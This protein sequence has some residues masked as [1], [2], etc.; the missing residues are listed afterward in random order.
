MPDFD[1]SDTYRRGD[2]EFDLPRFAVH[3]ARP[4]PYGS[5]SKSLGA[6]LNPY[7]NSIVYPGP[8][9]A[10]HSLSLSG[11]QPQHPTRLPQI[12]DS[13]MLSGAANLVRSA[14][15]SGRQRPGN[16]PQ[17]DIERAYSDASVSRQPQQHPATNSLYPSS[18][19]YGS[20]AASTVDP[21]SQAHEGPAYTPRRSL[22]HIVHPQSGPYNMEAGYSSSPVYSDPYAKNGDPAPVLNTPLQNM[23]SPTSPLRHPASL[24]PQQSPNLQP[25]HHSIS[26]TFQRSA[27]THELAQ[28]LQPTSASTIPSPY[29][30][31][32][33]RHGSS[34]TPVSPMVGYP[35]RH[36]S[37]QMYYQRDEDSAVQPMTIDSST[38]PPLPQQVGFRRI[39][40]TR[41][42]RPKVNSQP[43][44]RRAD[45][46]GGGV[47][48]SPLRS[49]TTNLAQTY[50][51]CNPQFRYESTHN[52]RRVLTKPSKPVH[53]DG[54]DNEDYDYILYVNDC[55]GAEDSGNRYL[56]LDVLGQGTFGQVVKCQNMKTHEIVAVKVVKNKPAYFNQSMMEVTILELLNN[57][58]DPHDEHHILRLRDTFIHKNHLCLVFE[59]LS[60][61]LY[62]LIKQNSFGGLSTQLVKVFTQ[63]LLDSLSILNE[64]KLIHCDL[65]PENILLVSLQTPQIKII[66]FGSA[67]HERQTVYTYIQ[68]RFYRSPE[69]LLGLPYTSAIDMWSLGCIAVELFLGLP[70]FPGTS[71]YNQI[72]RI[73]D[74]LGMPPQYML[75]MGK[76]TS[77]FFSPYSDE[78]GRKKHRLKSLEQYSREH[79]TPEQPGK[80]YFTANTLPEIIRT[81]P[82]PK[83]ATKPADLEK[84]AQNR[85]AFTD[86]VQGLLQIDPLLRWTPQQARK[87]P[88]ITGEK[89]IRPFVPGDLAGRT[90]S[91]S[92]GSLPPSVDPKRPYGGLVPSQ[93]KGTRAYQDA[94]SYNQHLAQHQAYTAQAASQA[95]Q[96]QIRNPYMQDHQ[97]P[98]VQG[99]SYERPGYSSN[100]STSQAPQ[101]YQSASQQP[102]TQNQQQGYGSSNDMSNPPSSFYPPTR[103]RANTI[104]QMDTAVP[105]Q[106]AR[107]AS[108]GMDV[109][110]IKRNTLTPVLNREEAIREWERR[111]AGHAPPQASYPQLEYLQQQAEL[112]SGNWTTS[113]ASHSRRYAPHQPSSL[114]FQSPP[115]AVVSD[116]SRHLLEKNTGPLRDI[117]LSSTGTTAVS[118][119]YGANSHHHAA[120]PNAP[121]QVYNSSSTSGRYASNSTSYPSSQ[122]QSNPYDSYDHRDGMGTLYAPLQPNVLTNQGQQSLS[123]SSSNS[124]GNSLAAAASSFY[125]GRVGVS[126]QQQPVYGQPSQQSQQGPLNPPPQAHQVDMWSR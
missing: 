16:H 92:P 27:S 126:N 78:Y 4:N 6:P 117:T 116:S 15:M 82:Q 125:G 36:Q 98:V 115:S 10:V 30:L 103:A 95:A 89:F 94:A 28:Q 7:S 86:F 111:R 99:Q 9:Q 88:F 69:V 79:G 56:I 20:G 29:N 3:E 35:S 110:G 33:S 19:V 121:P 102:Q 26:S 113:P 39:R 37:P 85:A 1:S 60:S 120:L 65:K 93:P 40:D 73:I 71:E 18:V 109:A 80:K 54:Y 32:T 47:Y 76:Q 83:S 70:L 100:I 101:S 53:N 91:Q 34:S 119:A 72:T 107:I 61:N 11:R 118:D 41:D 48:L 22:T 8:P 66:D 42:L 77:Q 112:A 25:Y 75:E 21:N 123:T 12:I 49:L 122:S 51:I 45:Y 5:T 87:H 23:K 50:N 46:S 17:D 43:S 63:Q 96:Q 81:A 13:D 62:E 84:E 104:N 59:L 31:S 105:P 55:L 108:L 74:M 106:L 52:P 58:W 114:Q 2:D 124:N 68:S 67:C 44:G 38:R 24:T 97:Q 90:Q 64:A 57:T 14:S